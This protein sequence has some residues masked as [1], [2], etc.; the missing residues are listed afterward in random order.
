MTTHST[1]NGNPIFI[2]EPPALAGVYN[3]LQNV[4]GKLILQYGDWAKIEIGGKQF[5]ITDTHTCYP[6]ICDSTIDSKAGK[7]LKSIIE[8]YCDRLQPD[9]PRYINLNAP[10]RTP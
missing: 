9:N 4:G 5:F 3:L 6:C 1:L 2:S 7:S 10:P 8:D